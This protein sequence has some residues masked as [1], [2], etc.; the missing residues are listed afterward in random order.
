MT[1]TI[2]LSLLLLVG[3]FFV[4]GCSDDDDNLDDKRKFFPLEEGN[5]WKFQ[6]NIVD[7]ITGEVLETDTMWQVVMGDTA[8]DGHNY[9]VVMDLPDTVIDLYRMD[10]D[11]LW[12]V[13][14]EHSPFGTLDVVF[15]AIKLNPRVGDTWEHVSNHGVLN[16]TITGE[17]R[18]IETVEV[19]SGTFDNSYHIFITFTTGIAAIPADSIYTWVVPELGPIKYKT[20]DSDSARTRVRELIEYTISE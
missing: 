1:K 14:R 2:L 3:S 6:S 20:F 19:P 17:C 18:A 11:F 15:K 9:K 5:R 8:F 16:I 12:M 7:D 13:R 10:D 4:I